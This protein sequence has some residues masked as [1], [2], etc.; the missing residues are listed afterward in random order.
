LILSL[1]VNIT[2]CDIVFYMDKS[3]IFVE[4]Y[5]QVPSIAPDQSLQRM[6]IIRLSL[7][8][9][10]IAC[11]LSV[12]LYI[13]ERNR[14]VEEI[15]ENTLQGAAYLRA[16]II[17]QLDAPGLGNHASINNTI[18]QFTSLSLNFGNA[19]T[20]FIRVY[21]PSGKEIVR[22]IYDQYDKKDSIIRYADENRH[23]FADGDWPTWKKSFRDNGR[24][25][26]YI[27]M[28]LKNS[29][30]VVVA[31]ADSIHALHPET[32]ASIERK[33]WRTIGVSSLIVFITTAL[34][35]PVILHLLGR[36]STLSVNLFTANM[37]ALRMLGSAIA[38]RDSDTDTHNYR[39][40]I[41]ATRL[42]EAIGV[43]RQQI[44]SL[45][46]GAFVHDVGKIGIRDAVLLKPGRLTEEEF[47][48]MKKHVQHGRDIVQRSYWLNDTLDVV[49]GHHEKYDG[50]GYDRGLKGA[51]IPLHARIFAIADVF[52][53]LTSKRPYKEPFSYEKA[54]SIM[55][56]ARSTHFDPELL[57]AFTKI[58][59]VLFDDLAVS[60]DERPR[61]YLLRILDRYVGRDVIA[62][63]R[64][65]EKQAVSTRS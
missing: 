28:Q 9:V 30:G 58:A 26:V 34:L 25:Y 54:M 21:T 31:C 12:V 14:L 13:S 29:A 33:T 4:P 6:L 18:D 16:L 27:A 39:V 10:A 3:Q 15:T 19:K 17:N 55:Q 50:S 38:K 61:K 32:L 41:Y 45:M 42:A 63:M 1:L 60:D 40:T 36:L 56:E 59:R 24:H 62:M 49:G 20:V 8:A 7:L 22:Y 43:E 44:V 64:R 52:D 47:N 11:I 57:D 2:V 5:L 46:K 23:R 65:H 53:A 51:D 37:E 35:Y 48:E